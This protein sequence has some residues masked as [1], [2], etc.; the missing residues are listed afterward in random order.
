MIEERRTRLIEHLFQKAIRLKTHDYPRVKQNPDDKKDLTLEFELEVNEDLL[1]VALVETTSALNGCRYRA[2]YGISRKN[3][4]LVNP[5]IYIRRDESCEIE[6]D[7][8]VNLFALRDVYEIELSRREQMFIKA[9]LDEQFESILSASCE[10][11]IEDEEYED[12]EEW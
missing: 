7:T 5:V 2:E 10:E 12:D 3:L 6:D 9:I 1:A 8:K 4:H 11:L